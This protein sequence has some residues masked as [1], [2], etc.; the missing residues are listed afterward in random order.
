[1]NL[2][3]SPEDFVYRDGGLGAF[4]GTHEQFLLDFLATPFL[5]NAKKVFVCW[6]WNGECS[7]EEAVLDRRNLLAAF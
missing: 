4:I 2:R 3:K 1:M 7:N 6:L 5:G